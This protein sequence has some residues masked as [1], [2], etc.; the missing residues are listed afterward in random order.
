[1]NNMQET[2]DEINSKVNKIKKRIELI[3]LIEESSKYN[4]IESPYQIDRKHSLDF[5]F[6]NR[7]LHFIF[8]DILEDLIE[9]D[10]KIDL[11]IRKIEKEINVKLD[12]LSNL[13]LNNI[14]LLKTKSLIGML[15]DSYHYLQRVSES[16]EVNIFDMLLENKKIE[17][18]LEIIIS[19]KVKINQKKY[20]LNQMMNKYPHLVSSLDNMPSLFYY[21]QECDYKKLYEEKFSQE[22]HLIFCDKEE[23]IAIVRDNLKEERKD[24]ITKINRRNVIKFFI[25]NKLVDINEINWSHK[26]YSEINFAAASFLLGFDGLGK[27][28][29]SM[30]G[31]KKTDNN[32]REASDKLIIDILIRDLGC[33]KSVNDLCELIENPNFE[34]S[35]EKFD[36]L[37]NLFVKKYIENPTDKFKKEINK[38]VNILLRKTKKEDYK[39]IKEYIK[40]LDINMNSDLLEQKRKNLTSV[41]GSINDSLMEQVP[42]KTKIK[43]IKFQQEKG[44]SK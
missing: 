23:N 37:I 7:E 19:D 10:F 36:Y 29:Y 11:D 17:L 40:N 42:A 24:E 34:G 3:E 8:D 18:I 2:L 4:G 20:L 33:L 39:I 9:L 38:V 43:D 30:D 28:I 12:S 25:D 41:L 15:V 5:D 14:E 6:K 21:A 44:T 31:Y 27:F 16:K 35:P 1:M 22:L 32:I 13:D 26:N